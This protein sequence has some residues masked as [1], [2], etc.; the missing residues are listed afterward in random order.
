MSKLIKH[1]L[2]LTATVVTFGPSL[3]LANEVK[4]GTLEGNMLEEPPM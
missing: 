2:A 3:E 4:E 1:N